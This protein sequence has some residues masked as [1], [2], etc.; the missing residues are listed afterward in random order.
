MPLVAPPAPKS[1]SYKVKPQDNPAAIAQSNNLSV[2]E[3]LAANKGGYPFSTGQTIKIP[4]PVTSYNPRLPDI[5]GLKPITTPQQPSFQIRGVRESFDTLTKMG[6]NT[7]VPKPFQ[8]VPTK[9]FGNMPKSEQLRGGLTTSVSDLEAQFKDQF[10]QFLQGNGTLPQSLS[11]S[12]MQ[13]LARQGATEILNFYNS[14]GGL[15]VDPGT[16]QPVAGGSSQG[17]PTWQQQSDATNIKG[18]TQYYSNTRGYFRGQAGQEKGVGTMVKKGGRWV[19]KGRGGS[20]GGGGGGA[21]KPNAMTGRQNFG[22][23]NFSAGTG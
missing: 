13:S 22:L 14:A 10:N 4:K 19:L 2:T 17:S 9:T 6:F 15:I 16:G 1:Y 21:P 18:N 23:V 11:P 20:G 3:L 12:V 7:N 8:P 5:T